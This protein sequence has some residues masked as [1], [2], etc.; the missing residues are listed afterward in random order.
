MWRNYLTVGL[1]ALAKS[2]T[3]TF[4]NVFG[5]AI[6]MAA[7]LLILLY[8][9]Y[10]TSFDEWLP[11]AENV[12]AVQFAGAPPGQEKQYIQMAP[13]PASHALEK[14]FPQVETAVSTF[15]A[16]PVAKRGA[17][18]LFVDDALIADASFFDV[19]ELPFVHGN[20]AD[21]LKNAA[22]AVVTQTEAKRLFGR[23]NVVGETLTLVTRGITR[24]YRI[25]GIL[26]DI[27]DNSSLQLSMV[28]RLDLSDYADNPQALRSFGSVNGYG[29]VKLKPGTS[30]D[31]INAQMEQFL[32][33]ASPPEDVGNG[34]KQSIADFIDLSLTNIRDV[35]LGRAQGGSMT[36]GNDMRTVTTFAIVALLILGMAC[37]NFTNLATA[38]ASQRAREVALRKVLGAHRGQLVGQFLG[39]SIL[40]AAFAMLLALALTELAL[41]FLSD[42]LDAK[43]DLAYIGEG[44]VLGWAVLLVLVVGLLGGLYPAFYLSRFQ[45]AKVLKANKSAAD[46]Q[47]S[48][49]LRSILVVGQF[50]VSIGLI[51]CTAVVYAQTLH[52]RNTD[53]GYKREGLLIVDGISRRQITP[54]TA[55]TFRNRVAKI[56][57]VKNAARTSIVPAQQN[58][59]NTNYLVPGHSTPELIGFYQVDPH[60]LDTM[61]LQLVAGRNL[62]E[63]IALDRVDISLSADPAIE[64]ALAARGG[65]FLLNEQAT[66]KLG[67]A[68]AKDA[69]GKTVQVG[70]IDPANGGLVP[71]TVAGVVKDAQFR[72]AR[73]NFEPVGFFYS[74]QAMSAVAVRYDSRNPNEVRDRIAAVWRELIPDVPFEAEFAED[75]VAELYAADKARGQ[76]FAMFAGLSVIVGCLGLFGLAAF[77]AERRTKEIGIRKVLGARTQDI[78]RLLVWQFSKPVVVANLIAWPVAW[79]LMRDWLN[80]FADRISLHPGWFLGAG[81]LAMLIAAAT[82]I[83]H[84]IKVARANPVFALRYE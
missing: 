62:S 5:L 66:K 27:P 14:E 84:A 72:S 52:A 35:H 54:A 12:Y 74:P 73:D 77:T 47:G 22:S 6:G 39:E 24:D 11:G 56:E 17:E 25:T 81:L 83:S 76:I 15:Q 30:A 33:R 21:A 28:V 58:Q 55:E 23:E 42:F 38:R 75:S 64:K 19:L 2:P 10:E 48:G 44:G 40:V 60:Y 71:M 7:C 46:A 57:G 41:P 59:N 18:S 61:Q 49:L 31:T 4:I 26:K 34:M 67:F 9:R 43:L 79:W 65:N 29:W 37:V 63:N 16:R 8:V 82:I 50:A 32:R 80:G 51:I 13:Y 36:P 70:L 3:Y 45:P 78:V 20:R 69:I 53:P 68:N 1:R